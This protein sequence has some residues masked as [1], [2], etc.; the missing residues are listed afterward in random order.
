MQATMHSRE[1]DL[2]F[3][4]SLLG[5]TGELAIQINAMGKP[6]EATC[7]LDAWAAR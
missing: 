7:T 6:V 1:G 5:G 2:G 4:L 3:G